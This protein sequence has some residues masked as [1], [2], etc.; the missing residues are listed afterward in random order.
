MNTA[1]PGSRG[2][3]PRSLLA[4]AERGNPVRVRGRRQAFP[5]KPEATKA[6]LPGGTRMPKKRMPVR[7]KATGNRGMWPA[8]RPGVDNR[9]EYRAAARTRKGADVGR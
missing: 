9:P 1:G 7:R 3:P 5:G 8:F 4:H 6:Q 2:H